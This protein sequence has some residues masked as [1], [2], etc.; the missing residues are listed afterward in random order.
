MEKWNSLRDIYPRLKEGDKVR[1]SPDFE[2]F[3]HRNRVLL[4]VSTSTG[5]FATGGDFR[6]SVSNS[7][8]PIYQRVVPVEIKEED[9][10]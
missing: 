8:R 6:Q 7:I 2:N 10:L 3:L 5:L 1:V 4:I 9:F